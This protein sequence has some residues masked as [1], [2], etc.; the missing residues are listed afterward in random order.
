MNFIHAREWLEAGDIVIVDCSH[1]CNVRLT[2]DVNFQSLRRGGQHRYY[3]GFFK[4]FPARIQVPHDGNWN[5][6]IDLGG[7]RA[8]IR[9]NIQYLRRNAA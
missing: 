1:Q 5:I 3:G 8:T 6:T 4:R 2:D 7:G 9:H